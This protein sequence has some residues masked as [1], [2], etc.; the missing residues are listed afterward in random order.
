MISLMKRLFYSQWGVRWASPS[1]NC[2]PCRIGWHIEYS[3]GCQKQWYKG[4]PLREKRGKEL[5]LHKVTENLKVD[6]LLNQRIL[7]FAKRAWSYILAYYSLNIDANN[8][9]YGNLSPQITERL[10]KSFKCHCSALD[11]NAQGS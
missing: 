1:I 8:A 11:F 4:L 10:A 7:Y 5:F 6:R 3:W 2:R 9:D